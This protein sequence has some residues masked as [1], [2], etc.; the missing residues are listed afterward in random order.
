MFKIIYKFFIAPSI[1]S[2]ICF[3]KDEEDIQKVTNEAYGKNGPV[4]INVNNNVAN[5]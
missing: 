3:S 5:K 1:L 4:F 2:T